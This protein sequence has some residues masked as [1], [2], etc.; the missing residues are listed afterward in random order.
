MF[1]EAI[2]VMQLCHMLEGTCSNRALNLPPQLFPPLRVPIPVV[3]L[4][5]MQN[6]WCQVKHLV[7]HHQQRGRNKEGRCSNL[8]PTG[9]EL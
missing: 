3:K 2:C 8:I 7:R 5:I 4:K 1:L 6:Y 9:T